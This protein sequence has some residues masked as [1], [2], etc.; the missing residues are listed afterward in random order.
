MSTINALDPF[1]SVGKGNNTIY[2]VRI[3]NVITPGGVCT[4]S[5]ASD[6]LNSEA[7]ALLAFHVQLSSVMHSLLLDHKCAIN[8]P[9][10]SQEPRDGIGKAGMSHCV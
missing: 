5:A 1:R 3:C 9:P 2:M 10:L 7:D 8:G 4:C 6:L